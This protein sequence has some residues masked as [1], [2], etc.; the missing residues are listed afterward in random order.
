MEGN[1]TFF[2]ALLERIESFSKT[3]IDLVKLKAVDKLA[4]IAS[5]IV[6]GILLALFGF[7]FFLILNMALA[8]WIGDLIGKTHAGFF[9]LA[10]FYVL[11]M[12]VLILFKKQLI[13]SPVS[14]A[15]ISK[16]LK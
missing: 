7:F 6:Y 11:L 12:I 16:F 14:N 2:G 13:K 15:I 10:G 9:I 1:T 3:T 8:F 4:A 5:N